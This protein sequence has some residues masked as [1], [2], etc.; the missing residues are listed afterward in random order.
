L[1]G[2]F[3]EVSLHAPD[4][5]ESIA[6]WE[7]LGFRQ[8]N[9]NDVWSHPYAVLSDGRVLLGLHAYRFEHS[10]A[11]SFVRPDLAKHLPSLRALGVAFEFAKTAEDQFH[12]AGFLSPDGQMVALLESRTYSPPMFDESDFS[13]FG[14]HDALHLPVRRM[15]E[16][17]P[18]WAQLGMTILEFDEDH[19]D[20]ALLTSGALSLR[21]REDRALR[22]PTLTFHAEHLDDVAEIVA[23]RV[24]A[25][26]RGRDG[27][28]ELVSLEG[29]PIR[30]M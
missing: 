23:N 13:V 10:P 1:I 19:P 2:R 11:L 9:T 28:L 16:A 12:E 15:D 8:V 3:L 14:R 27:A 26:K 17:L 30:I 6:F 25:P 24:G 7:A 22:A 29:L 4:I 20:T 5:L 18:F 21:L